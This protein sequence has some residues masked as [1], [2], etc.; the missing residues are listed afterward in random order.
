MRFGL[1]LQLDERRG[2]GHNQVKCCDFSAGPDAKT[3]IELLETKLW[4]H[5]FIYFGCG[6]KIFS[7]VVRLPYFVPVLLFDLSYCYFPTYDAEQ[8]LLVR[9]KNPRSGIAEADVSDGRSKLFW[10]VRRKQILRHDV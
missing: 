2:S 10:D 4:R 1:Y 7:D 3:A 6:D 8:A 5:K 9:I